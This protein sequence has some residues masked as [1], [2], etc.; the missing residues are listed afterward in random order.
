MKSIRKQINKSKKIKKMKTFTKI[1]IALVSALGSLTGNAQQDAMYTHYMYN[2]LA[3]NPAYAGSRDALTVTALDRYQWVGFS[4][5]PMTQ[6]LTMHAPLENQHIGLGLS[7][8]ND[9]IGPTNNTSLFADFAYIMQVTE[10]SKLSLGLSA[11]VNIWQASLNTLAHDQQSDPVFQNNINN[12]LT[13]NIGFGA[14]YYR[15]RFY[16]GVSVPGLVQNNLS[17]ITQDNGTTLIGI[18]QRNYYLIAGTVLNITNNLAF[19]PTTLIKVTAGAPAQADLT[20][21]F[22]IM[23]KFLVGAMFRTG[24]AWGAL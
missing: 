16:V 8:L 4:G 24:D 11:G 15:E 22:I 19:K 10:K 3:V 12:K 7:M 18:E 5:A 14:Y 9:K 17:A 23:K 2:T 20:G 21:C 6:T 13:P 1:S